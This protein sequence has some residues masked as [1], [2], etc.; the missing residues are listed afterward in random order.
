MKAPNVILDQTTADEYAS[1]FRCL[2]DGTR[3]R[4]LNAVANSDHP[5]T[6]GEIVEKVGKSQSTVSRHLRIL[7]DE[8]YVLTE[9]DGV[10]T[11]VTINEACMVA[12]PEAAAAIM[13][14]EHARL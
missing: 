11:L 7:A 5:M 12:L 4:I 1:W 3:V 9:P 8:R 6:V 14:R 10:R 13:A 2:S